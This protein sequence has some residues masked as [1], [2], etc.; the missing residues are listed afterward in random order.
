MDK[1]NLDKKNL[2]KFGIIM[3]SA[4]LGIAVFI[5]LRHKYNAAPVFLI[6]FLFFIFAFLLP[7]LLRL[8]YIFWMRLAFILSWIN[9]RLLL[10][11]VF[12]LLFTPMG[13]AIK[14]F[15]VDLL[16]RKIQKNKASYWDKKVDINSGALKYERQF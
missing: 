9:T 4:F 13:L 7:G 8:V 15:R 14:L 12:Y 5:S 1:L 2:K 3:G 6:S 16:A 11:I 10:L